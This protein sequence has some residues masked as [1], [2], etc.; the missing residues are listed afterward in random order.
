MP[1]EE[2]GGDPSA[3]V[4][5]PLLCMKERAFRN[6][7]IGIDDY[8]VWSPKT[9]A[10]SKESG[11]HVEWTRA[12]EYSGSYLCAPPLSPPNQSLGIRKRQTSV[13]LSR[14]SQILASVIPQDPR[15]GAL[16]FFFRSDVCFLSAYLIPGSLSRA[17]CCT[18]KASGSI[19][20]RV[21]RL[22]SHPNTRFAIRECYPVRIM[23]I[24]SGSCNAILAGLPDVS[25]RGALS[26]RKVI[27]VSG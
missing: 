23:E 7:M 19:D 8:G 27:S 20:G 10:Y 12:A 1:P 2:D 21:I 3:T 13:F 15:S 25:H 17:R 14:G 5:P 4:L 16:P 26:N 6:K 9:R 24:C 22:S 11:E 18:S